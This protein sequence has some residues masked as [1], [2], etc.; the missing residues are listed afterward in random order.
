MRLLACFTAIGALMGI[1]LPLPAIRAQLAAAIDAIVQVARGPDGRRRVSAVAELGSAR[2]A[3]I[4]LW[5]AT[6]GVGA[7]PARPARRAEV[8]IEQEWHRCMQSL[9]A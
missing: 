9:P 2:R 4:T 6:G 7:S 1:A 8:D 3:P 5:S